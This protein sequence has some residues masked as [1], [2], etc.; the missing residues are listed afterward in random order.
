VNTEAFGQVADP[1][2]TFVGQDQIAH[3]AGLESSLDLSR[4]VLGQDSLDR[5]TV[6][7]ASQIRELGV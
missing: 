1:C 6:V 2:A 5:L 4:R 3:G 7:M